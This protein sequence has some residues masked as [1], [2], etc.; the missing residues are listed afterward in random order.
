MSFTLQVWFLLGLRCLCIFRQKGGLIYLTSGFFPKIDEQLWVPTGFSP[1]GKQLWWWGAHRGLGQAGAH[2]Y[3]RCPFPTSPRFSPS[4][5]LLL[6][7][8]LGPNPVFQGLRK[9]I[10][11]PNHFPVTFNLKRLHFTGGGWRRVSRRGPAYWQRT[12]SNFYVMLLH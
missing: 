4:Y 10:A 6:M 2:N 1:I 11:Y 8:E 5:S 12:K 3:R 7:R 9:A